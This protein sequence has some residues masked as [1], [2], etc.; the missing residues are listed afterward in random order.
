MGGSGHF[1]P[2]WTTG[3]LLA[4]SLPALSWTLH[5]VWFIRK[6]CTAAGLYWN[7]HFCWCPLKA[8]MFLDTF[9]KFL[10]SVGCSF[11][12]HTLNREEWDKMTL[13]SLFMLICSLRNMRPKSKRNNLRM[14]FWIFFHYPSFHFLNHLSSVGSQGPGT[15]PSPSW[16]ACQSIWKTDNHT[17]CSQLR[18]NN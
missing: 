10:T 7:S 9:H 16:T 17:H 14:R 5:P 13:F 4:P 6:I 8:E 1:C 11:C 2:D 12:K 15:K 3:I 18:M